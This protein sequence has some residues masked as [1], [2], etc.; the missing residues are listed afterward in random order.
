MRSCL[1]VSV[2]HGISRSDQS[3]QLGRQ[4]AAVE[5]GPLE[6]HQRARARPHGP[7]PEPAAGGGP[8]GLPGRAD[9]GAVSAAASGTRPRDPSAEPAA[10]L[11]RDACDCHPG[12][13]SR[14]FAGIWLALDV[15]WGH[16]GGAAK[17]QEKDYWRKNLATYRDAKVPDLKH[18]DARPRPLSRARAVTTSRE[19]TTWSTPSEQPLDE[20]LLTG[21][22]HWEKLAWTMDGEPCA[23]KNSAG[24]YVF[25][26]PKGALAPGEIVRIGFEHEGTFPRGIS[27]NG[28][29]HDGV[30]PAV[31]R[32][33]DELSPE[34]RADAGLRRGRRHRRR[35]SPGPQGVSATTSTRDRPTRSWARAR[36]SR[37]RSRSPV[38]PISRS[39][40]WGPRPRTP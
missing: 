3:D 18:V 40:R 1:A 29:G 33:A 38:R 8:G 5:R 9:A 6:R 34:H 22:P 31:G 12:S 37:P 10:A 23:P 36:R 7:R 15:G 27:K 17:K 16:E 13:S 14:S 25:T 21:G 20:I 24:L 30:H 35:E 19:R 32:G 11:A 2:L 28:G 26:P 4:L 39:T